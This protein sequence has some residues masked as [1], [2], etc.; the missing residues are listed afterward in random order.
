MSA[1][2]ASGDGGGDKL[3]EPSGCSACTGIRSDSL[4]R[5]R[6]PLG[7][8]QHHRGA[9]YLARSGVPGELGP[10]AQEAS[11]GFPGEV[12]RNGPGRVIHG[13]ENSHDS[14]MAL[15]IVDLATGG[16]PGDYMPQDGGRGDGSGAWIPGMTA[17]PIGWWPFPSWPELPAAG[18]GG[19]HR[20][21]PHL[22]RC[23]SGRTGRRCR[24]QLIA[25]EPRPARQGSMRPS[26]GMVHGSR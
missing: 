24:S 20:D 11:G 21:S 13:S 12:D 8:C 5:R 15:M 17:M 10:R 3:Q 6:W 2:P 1:G 14:R 18:C 22:Y 4:S 23:P 19:G 25:P 16:K 7:R 9:T 26:W